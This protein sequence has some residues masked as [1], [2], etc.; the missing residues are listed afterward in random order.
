M[1]FIGKV[2]KAE[3]DIIDRYL[4]ELMVM[5]RT[6]YIEWIIETGT[7]I[8]ICW[9]AE[10]WKTSCTINDVESGTQCMLWFNIGIDTKTVYVH[11]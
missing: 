9:G 7:D 2:K 5:A 6:K 1:T 3:S 11:I 10:D 4:P 8:A